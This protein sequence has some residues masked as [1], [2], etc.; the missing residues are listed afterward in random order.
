MELVEALGDAAAL[1][2]KGGLC[3][4]APLGESD[5]A[6]ESDAEWVEAGDALLLGNVE[7]DGPACD[8]A[9][10]ALGDGAKVAESMEEAPAEGASE[11][12]APG[13]LCP[14][15]AQSLALGHGT[16]SAGVPPGQ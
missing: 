16:R 13:A 4:K 6:G 11:A 10:E 2:D 15:I 3:E 8:G 9:Y 14:A 1:G 7:G 12:A 5:G